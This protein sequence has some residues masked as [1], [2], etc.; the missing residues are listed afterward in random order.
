MNKIGVLTNET[1]DKNLIYTKKIIDFLLKEEKTPLLPYKTAKA[2]G[3]SE[4]GISEDYIY[5]YSDMALVLG[6]DG[7]VL[8]AGRIC[9]PYKT[10]VMGINLGR[11]GYL[12]AADKAGAETALKKVFNGDFKLEKRVMLNAF[13]PDGKK[14]LALNDVC[15]ARG[16][17][18]KVLDFI[19]YINGERLDVYRADGVIIATP[20]GSTAYNLSAGG[21]ILKPDTETMAITP[22]CAHSLSARSTVV[23]T[24]DD[25]TV[26]VK[27]A[28]NAKL[29][30]SLDGQENFDIYPNDEIKIKKA[31][32]YARFIKTENQGFYDILRQKLDRSGGMDYYENV[33]TN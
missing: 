14:A 11:L 33:K 13:L 20:T 31:P 21:P 32:V 18:A 15:V 4:F 22:I 19:I 5:K 6:G 7:T 8:N 10:P 17:Y 9:A 25:I 24:S 1:R 3:L 26:K 2:L 23:S 29:I 30:V 27:C 28:Y 12:T 16:A